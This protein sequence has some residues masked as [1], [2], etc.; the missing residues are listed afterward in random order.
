VREKVWEKA[1]DKAEIKAE[2]SEPEDIAY[3]LNA[4]QNLNISKE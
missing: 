2:H 4:E 1:A 3:V